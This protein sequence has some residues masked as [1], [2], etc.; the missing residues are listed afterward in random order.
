M[1][2]APHFEL[3]SDP[4]F[5]WVST[6]KY[7]MGLETDH[8]PNQAPRK[9]PI[10]SIAAIRAQRHFERHDTNLV[11]VRIHVCLTRVSHPEVPPPGDCSV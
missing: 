10:L 2:H 11:L 6:G 1:R 4:V 7:A 9:T 8:E 5:W 3:G